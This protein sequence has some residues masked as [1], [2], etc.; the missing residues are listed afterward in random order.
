MLDGQNLETGTVSFSV[1]I[2]AGLMERIGEPVLVSCSSS[3]A[4]HKALAE[5]TKKNFDYEFQTDDGVIHTIWRLSTPAEY[6]DLLETLS[7]EESF[8]IADGHHRSA[9]ASLYH[10][11]M[12]SVDGKFLSYILPEDELKILPF[13]RLMNLKE[14]KGKYGILGEIEKQFDIEE[15]DEPVIPKEKGTIGLC[16]YKSWYKLTFKGEREVLLDVQLLEKRILKP[17]FDVEDSRTDERLDYVAGDEYFVPED[18]ADHYDA[19]FTLYPVNFNSVKSIADDNK[20]MPP[21][22][23]YILPKL[24]SG[25]LI[26]Q[27]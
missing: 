27:V 3:F 6:T 14:L 25:L 13:H 15:S 10:K 9:A 23:T 24:R 4:L 19:I 2:I 12:N 5:Q 8:Y 21:K 18:Y 16:L 1:E 11:R 17:C 26:Q 7:K 20:T 22:S